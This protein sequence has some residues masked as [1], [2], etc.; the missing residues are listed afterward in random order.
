LPDG[1]YISVVTDTT[2]L[3]EA[4]AEISHRAE[5]CGPAVLQCHG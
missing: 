3:A 2:A 1:G 5:D 4:E